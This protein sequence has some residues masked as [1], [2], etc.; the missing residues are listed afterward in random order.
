MHKVAA[1]GFLNTNKNFNKNG[2][3]KEKKTEPKGSFTVLPSLV[4]FVP[5]AKN[6]T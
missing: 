1:F 2:K 5:Q 4:L 3:K 6:K